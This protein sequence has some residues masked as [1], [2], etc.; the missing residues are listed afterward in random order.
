MP[1]QNKRF[2]L[3]KETEL[4]PC[5]HP[6]CE[7]LHRRFMTANTRGERIVHEI[8]TTWWLVVD[9]K[10]GNQMHNARTRK[11]CKLT[12]DRLNQRQGEIR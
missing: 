7:Q 6:L 5:E 8:K 4:S 3:E 9:S 10:T 1:R 2:V 11:E 12:A